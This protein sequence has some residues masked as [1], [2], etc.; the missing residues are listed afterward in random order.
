MIA[1]DG[2]L[3]KVCR[4]YE[5]VENYEKAVSDE[6]QYYVLH[7]R[8]EIDELK[9]AKQLQEEGMYC[10]VEPE[11]LIFLTRSQHRKLHEQNRFPKHRLVVRMNRKQVIDK[12]DIQMKRSTITRK[13][14]SEAL[15]AKH[16]FN[17]GKI[18][19]KAKACP[20]GFV[21]GRLT[22]LRK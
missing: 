6:E 13:K 20:E 17:N 19:I 5:Q 12:F 1:S 2:T 22:K 15:T 16:W 3:R 4:N 10:N 8:R 11:E 9:S 21:K 14:I 18:E 7:H